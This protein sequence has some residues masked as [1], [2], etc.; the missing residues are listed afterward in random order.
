MTPQEIQAALETRLA[1]TLPTTPTA[2]PNIAFDPAVDAVDSEGNKILWI[3]PTNKPGT[4]EI[5]DFQEGEQPGIYIIQI[6]APE[7]EGEGDA[8]T[9]AGT[10][11]TAFR[12]Q[13]LSGVECLEPYYNDI[14]PDGYG[15]YQINVIIRWFVW[16]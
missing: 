6:F 14:G 4:S 11:I 1:A 2:W 10:I 12:R 5:A 9:T 15:W 7:G 8:N 16:V 3:K 13:T